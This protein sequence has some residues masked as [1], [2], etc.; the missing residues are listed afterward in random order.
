MPLFA[1][2]RDRVLDVGCEQ[3][4]VLDAGAAVVVEILLDLARAGAAAG[5]LIG[6]LIA[7]EPSDMTMLMSALYSVE[8][9]LSSKLIYRLNPSTRLYQSAQSSILPSSTF[10]TM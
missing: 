10:P 8:M 1:Q 6:N 2:R 9:S 5:S 7:C 3:R 4:D